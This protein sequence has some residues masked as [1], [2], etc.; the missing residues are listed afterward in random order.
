[1]CTLEYYKI[2]AIKL[3]LELTLNSKEHFA[4]VKHSATLISTPFFSILR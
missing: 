2:F 1:M 4:M 3:N